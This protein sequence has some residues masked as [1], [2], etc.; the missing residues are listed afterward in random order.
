MGRAIH[1][2]VA[3]RI[4]YHHPERSPSGNGG[5]FVQYRPDN[6]LAFPLHLDRAGGTDIESAGDS[7]SET[8]SGG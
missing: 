3:G 2:N 8:E 6:E 5:A 7:D 4:P 1:G